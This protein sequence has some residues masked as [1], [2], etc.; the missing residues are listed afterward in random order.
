M[1]TSTTTHERIVGNLNDPLSAGAKMV[2]KD[3]GGLFL[4]F[5]GNAKIRIDGVEFDL[6]ANNL[7]VYF[8]MSHLDVLYRSDDL[9]GIVMTT[10]MDSVQPLVSRVMHIDSLMEVR[11]HPVA[12]LTDQQMQHLRQFIDLYIELTE[13]ERLYA[14][15]GHERLW[16]LS[17]LQAE[18]VRECLLLEIVAVFSHGLSGAKNAVNH[19][20]ELVGRFLTDLQRYY[21]TEHEVNFYSERQCLTMRYFSYVVRGRTGRTPSQ[22]IANALLADAKRLLTE[23][24]K[25]VKEISEILHFPNQSYFGKWLKERTGVGPLEFKKNLRMTE[26]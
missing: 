10:D 3:R 6:S 1:I 21:R 22:W 24:E 11:Q 14:D 15:A 9:D 5:A 18:H 13:M 25:T 4:C 2:L 19:K 20:D 16:Q 26:S 12:Q 8:P 17:N 23:T 7:C